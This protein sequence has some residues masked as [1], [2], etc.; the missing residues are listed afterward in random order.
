MFTDSLKFLLKNDIHTMT[1]ISVFFEVLLVRN[2]RWYSVNN[3]FM[4]G[5]ITNYDNLS[6]LNFLNF[7]QYV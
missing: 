6:L 2:K 7:Q 1:A 5:C 3:S 4:R